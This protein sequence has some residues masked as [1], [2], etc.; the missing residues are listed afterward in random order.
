VMPDGS[1]HMPWDTRDTLPD[2]LRF[3]L[4]KR[5]ASIA[6]ITSMQDPAAN[7]IL[8]RWAGVPSHRHECVQALFGTT[9]P[10]Q[11]Q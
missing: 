11:D 3:Q 1:P 5:T 9:L 10:D 6:N 8:P 7:T 4:G 2:L